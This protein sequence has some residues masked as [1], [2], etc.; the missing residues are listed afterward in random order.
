MGDSWSILFHRFWSCVID[1]YTWSIKKKKPSQILIP[2]WFGSPQ[3]DGTACIL[4]TVQAYIETRVRPANTVNCRPSVSLNVKSWLTAVIS[5][6]LIMYLPST[7]DF[8][9]HQGILTQYST[10]WKLSNVSFIP[11][12]FHEIFTLLIRYVFY[13]A[14]SLRLFNSFLDSVT[15]F[16]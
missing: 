1:S 16:S 12:T 13:L 10:T 2:F 3:C 11:V 14:F 15:R 7:S 5:F 4:L 8:S 9:Q 6:T